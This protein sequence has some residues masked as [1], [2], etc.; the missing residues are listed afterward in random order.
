MNTVRLISDPKSHVS[1][2]LHPL[3]FWFSLWF[4]FVSSYLIIC[5]EFEF[6]RL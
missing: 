4:T 6:D 1:H 2:F 3:S 5:P